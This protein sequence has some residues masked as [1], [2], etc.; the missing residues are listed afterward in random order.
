MNTYDTYEK[1]YNWLD[2]LDHFTFLFDQINISQGKIKPVICNLDKLSTKR[3]FYNLIVADWTASTINQADSQLLKKLKSPID[4]I[5]QPLQL[6]NY[7]DT[8]L[9]Q[10]R[11]PQLFINS[12]LFTHKDIHEYVDCFAYFGDSLGKDAFEIG[13]YN[14][15]DTPHTNET[16]NNLEIIHQYEDLVSQCNLKKKNHVE[17]ERTDFSFLIKEIR[18]R[19]WTAKTGRNYTENDYF[20]LTILSDFLHDETQKNHSAVPLK[21]VLSDLNDL[22]QNSS[23]QQLNLIQL[24]TKNNDTAKKKKISDLIDYFKQGKSIKY[25]LIDAS[26]EA[27]FSDPNSIR[28][29][30]SAI[31]NYCEDNEQIQH[32]NFYT[33]STRYQSTPGLGKLKIETIQHAG[34][35]FQFMLR[36]EGNTDTDMQMKLLIPGKEGNNVIKFGSWSSYDILPGDTLD[37]KLVTSNDVIKGNIYLDIYSSRRNIKKTILLSIKP[38]LLYSTCQ[39]L[40]ILY[41]VM[42]VCICYIL[43]CYSFLYIHKVVNLPI[44]A[45][46]FIAII[47]LLDL[48]LVKLL[49]SY[50]SNIWSE[51][52]RPLLIFLT[53]IFV[54]GIISAILTCRSFLGTKENDPP[55]SQ[56]P[57]PRRGE[58][59]EYDF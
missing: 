58:I 57:D 56:N 25:N 55:K 59:K 2:P 1:E 31:A 19:I 34:E 46:F 36:S 33:P 30:Q 50:Y 8:F 51:T 14:S 37:C 21:R 52:T 5:Q 48:G 13:W 18:N 7:N 17:I 27:F 43:S 15:F 9:F 16:A 24:P 4:S 12:L 26:N 22:F 53:I 40:L 45:I 6:Y 38:V 41:F 32:L 39:I 3:N 42:F 23:F 35:G 10:Q 20:C 47:T 29:I 11:L 49:T 28:A 54:L 44:L